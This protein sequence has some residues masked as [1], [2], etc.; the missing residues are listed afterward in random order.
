MKKAWILLKASRVMIGEGN[1]IALIIFSAIS[2]IFAVGVIITF[3]GL[4]GFSNSHPENSKAVGSLLIRI[5]SIVIGY[6]FASSAYS[7]F[8]EAKKDSI[9]SN[10]RSFA[11]QLPVTKEDIIRAQFLDLLGCILPGIFMLVYMIVFTH[12]IK[13]GD[14]ISIHVG[15]M[16]SVFILIFLL[17]CTEKGIF[18]VIF[19]SNRFREMVY[20]GIAVSPALLSI[21]LNNEFGGLP[22]SIEKILH[23]GRELSILGSLWGVLMIG[24]AGLAGYYLCCF[25]PGK[26]Y[27][28]KEG[29]R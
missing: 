21:N 2:W 22:G 12:I 1:R 24:I 9:K 16:V 13:A 19:I 20:V 7:G 27:R 11:V 3:T 17:I 18:S 6:G 5:G 8:I 14:V 26:I 10:F 28:L 4:I 15:R 23:I 29:S 25:I